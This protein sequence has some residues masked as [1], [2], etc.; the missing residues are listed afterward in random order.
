[1]RAL[2]IIKVLMPSEALKMEIINTYDFLTPSQ[3]FEIDSIAWDTYYKLY[4][5][6]FDFNLELQNENVKAGKELVGDDFHARALRKTDIQMKDE[7]DKSLNNE[8][9]FIARKAME[10]IMN[11]IRASKQKA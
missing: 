3:K 2:D 8:N 7:F 4:N 11:E 5:A 9:I 6:K 10:K 1:M